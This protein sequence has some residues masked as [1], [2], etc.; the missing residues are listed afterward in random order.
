MKPLRSHLSARKLAQDIALSDAHKA[1][2]KSSFEGFLFILPHPLLDGPFRASPREYKEVQV[3]RHRYIAQGINDLERHPQ[4]AIKRIVF[5]ISAA[6]LSVVGRPL[7]R[8]RNAS[9]R[10]HTRAKRH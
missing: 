8:H 1:G 10:P 9:E 7:I 4:P 2:V 5:S 3:K 6:L